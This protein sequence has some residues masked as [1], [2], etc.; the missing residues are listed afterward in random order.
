M[1]AFLG[2]LLP[3]LV[4]VLGTALLGN[5]V[6]DVAFYYSGR[7]ANWDEFSGQA[8]LIAFAVGILLCLPLILRGQRR[9][10]SIWLLLIA[11]AAML[12]LVLVVVIRFAVYYN[13]GGIL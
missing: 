10:G 4:G 8:T 3:Y 9:H 12:H 13:A 6:G 5:K 2:V 1:A 11:F 7:L